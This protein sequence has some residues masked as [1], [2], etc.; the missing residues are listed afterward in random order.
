VL[1][2]DIDDFKSVNDSLG[3][4]AGDELLAQFAKQIE[5]SVRPGDTVAR[6]GGDEFAVLLEGVTEEWVAA[7]V[8][9][10]VIEEL[11]QEPFS[12]GR[13]EIFAAPSIGIALSG[14]AE[15]G[16]EDLLR[17]ADL[18]LHR[19][20]EEGKARYRCFTPDLD[21][22][23]RGRLKLEGE[24]REALERGEF[25]VFYQPKVSIASGEIV[26]MEALLRWEHPERGLLAPSAFLAVA[27]ET[28]LIVPAGEWVLRASCRQAKEWR[29]RYPHDP[30]LAI[31][32]NLS[33]KQ[34]RR[35]DL[36]EDVGAVLRECGLDPSGL[37]LEITESTAME[38]APATTEALKKLKI[39][40][41]RIE[42]DD[43]GT[44]YSSLSYL[45]RFP[46][47]Y[48]KV[49]RSFVGSLGHNPEDE[50][51]VRAIVE[52][53]HTLGLE[54]VAEGVETG[55]QLGLLREMGCE[56]AQGHYF[57]GALSAEAAGE[58]LAAY[59]A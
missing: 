41:V 54:V 47:D 11:K 33:A 52:L 22:L 5:A 40:G 56:L 28:G 13:R 50:G 15:R 12:I 45:K 21:E 36:A 34:F 14:H 49:D 51:I 20:K 35:R 57:W 37:T 59:H 44:G 2:V 29:E 24:L 9:K 18:A 16:W 3:H 55:E 39:R 23:L 46:V 43:F 58:L 10:R 42:V 48:L 17:R 26:G 7:E 1:F 6:F 53:A 38:D 32:V 25:R 27:E 30:P 4:W 31:S 19:A 8:A